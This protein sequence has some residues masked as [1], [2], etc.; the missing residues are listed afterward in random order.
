MFHTED[1]TAHI[2]KISDYVDPKGN[3]AV[4]LQLEVSITMLPT[5]LDLFEPGLCAAF[6]RDPDVISAQATGV[7]G[8]TR[9]FEL[10]EKLAAKVK[11]VGAIIELKRPGDLATPAEG[12]VLNDS[13]VD[14]IKINVMK[15]SI[16]IR[17]RLL[18]WPDAAGIS[19]IYAM[20]KTAILLTITPP[21]AEGYQ[22]DD[23]HDDD[24]QGSLDDD[25]GDHGDDPDDHD[26]PVTSD[27]LSPTAVT[28]DAAK[29]SR[30]GKAKPA[31][32]VSKKKSRAARAFPAALDGTGDQN[33]FDAAV[34]AAGGAPSETSQDDAWPFPGS[35]PTDTQ[36][37]AITGA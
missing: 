17:A 21:E 36:P 32:K 19:A 31:P 26:G 20:R 13:T 12:V 29:P 34:A 18:I 35:V 16:E 3:K 10:F 5:A 15:A 4:G 9:R 25:G 37:P 23:D 33:P 30:G 6:Y 28:A 11:I 2:E 8:K 24:R 27:D 1:E 14:H 22:E 7:V